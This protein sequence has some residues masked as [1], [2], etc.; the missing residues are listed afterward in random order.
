MKIYTGNGDFGETC[1]RGEKVKKSD[2]RILCLGTID[3]LAAAI[4]VARTELEHIEMTEIL[5]RIEKKLSKIA[6]I[7]AGRS[8]KIQEEEIKKIEELIDKYYIKQEG[9]IRPKTE[10][11]A[12]LNYARTVCRRT[13]FCINKL[14]EVPENIL[15]YINRL[16]DLLFA[17]AVYCDEK[18]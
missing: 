6:G 16:S 7:I 3:E 17:M 5:L 18:Q 14:E 9:F 2:E 12:L 15:K 10:E 4:A 1:L 13:E 8:D 11:G